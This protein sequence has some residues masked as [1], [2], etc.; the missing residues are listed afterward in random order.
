MKLYLKPNCTTC[1]REKGLLRE[2]G[3]V[4]E[5]VDL[6]KGLSVAQL[7]A[8]IGDRDYKA[9]LNTRNELYRERGMKQSPPSRAAAL[10]L[11]S[12]HPNLIRRPLLINDQGEASWPGRS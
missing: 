4:F 3:V 9:F 7:D 8:I 11:M 5:E 2:R 6:N 1:R 10:E 12:Q